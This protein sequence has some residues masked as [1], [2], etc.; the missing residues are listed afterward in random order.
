MTMFLPFLP[1]TAEARRRVALRSILWELLSRLPAIRKRGL[2]LSHFASR[3]GP[4]PFFLF[5]R[6]HLPKTI[7]I[8]ELNSFHINPAGYIVEM[9]T[10]F[11]I[12]A[13]A[14]LNF[15]QIRHCKGDMSS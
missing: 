10:S 11:G 9:G 1:N 8:F 2:A 13:L 5:L 12:S 3:I 4:V 15:V 14:G 6:G 7:E